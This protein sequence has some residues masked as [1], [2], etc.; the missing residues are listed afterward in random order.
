M[1]DAVL[2]GEGSCFL[3]LARLAQAADAVLQVELGD[4]FSRAQT[5]AMTSAGSVATRNTR[6]QLSG[7]TIDP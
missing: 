1:L 3:D 2:G 7:P 6:R 5:N 4:S